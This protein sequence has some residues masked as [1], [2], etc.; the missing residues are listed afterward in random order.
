MGEFSLRI[1]KDGDKWCVLMGENLQEGIA[2]FGKTIPDALYSLSEAW[3][4]QYC[5]E[6]GEKLIKHH[7]QYEDGKCVG[8]ECTNCEFRAGDV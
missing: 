1:F 5:P 7:S 3:E 2:G 8:V 6:C 4:S